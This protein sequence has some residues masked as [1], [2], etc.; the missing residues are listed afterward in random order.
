[1]QMTGGRIAPA[2]SEE[3]RWEMQYA[4]RWEACER[5]HTAAHAFLCGAF[6][7][8][9]DPAKMKALLEPLEAAIVERIQERRCP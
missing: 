2:V 6:L 7:A 3:L 5:P 8:Q 4:L 9:T 1:M